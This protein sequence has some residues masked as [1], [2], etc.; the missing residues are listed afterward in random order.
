LTLAG[1]LLH[2]IGAA[3]PT[4]PARPE[5]A[6][7]AMTPPGTDASQPAPVSPSPPSERLFDSI[8]EARTWLRAP[9]WRI[10]DV[11]DN[12]AVQQVLWLGAP[13]PAGGPS[14]D[15]DR[16]GTVQVR[17]GTPGGPTVF[18]LEQGPAIAVSTDGAPDG[19]WGEL[20][21]GDG[22][23][24]LWVLG[25]RPDEVET[26]LAVSDRPWACPVLGKGSDVRVGTA[27]GASGWRLTSTMMTLDQMLAIAGRMIYSG[28][29]VP[30]GTAVGPGR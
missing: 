24:L 23:R 7:T 12:L 16:R 8:D 27:P 1:V 5:T 9:L 30:D 28:P 25:N 13:L 29:A 17:Y 18:I 21:G 6:A 4:A 15:V 11:P 2:R 14:R 10:G 22:G 19:L 26:C 3:A 20:T